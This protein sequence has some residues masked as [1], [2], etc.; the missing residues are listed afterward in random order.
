MI[1]KIKNLGSINQ[2]EIDLS[3]DLILLCG[4]QDYWQ[5]YLTHTIYHL[6]SFDT[7]FFLELTKFAQWEDLQELVQELQENNRLE[8]NLLEK[9]DNY[10][11][12]YKHQI[13]STTT[14]YLREKIREIFTGFKESFI[15]TEIVIDADNEFIKRQ[16]ILSN[17]ETHFGNMQKGYFMTASKPSLSPMLSF[18]V[19]PQHQFT[20]ERLQSA[21][22]MNIFI[23]L[24]HSLLGLQTQ[25]FQAKQKFSLGSE[26]E[27]QDLAQQTSPFVYLADKLDTI[28]HDFPSLSFYLRHLAQPKDCLIIREPEQGLSIDNQIFIGNFIGN[29]VNQGFKVVISTNSVPLVEEIRRMIDFEQNPIL[30]SANSISLFFSRKIEWGRFSDN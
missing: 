16:I 15:N 24:V 13:L 3:K 10:F 21:I 11:L 4:E 29:L 20:T 14:T 22:S 7:S 19:T 9:V 27:V 12:P 25:I 17:Y 8:I 1:L 6:F 2:A 28:S 5:T 18:E 30:S 23:S 26:Q